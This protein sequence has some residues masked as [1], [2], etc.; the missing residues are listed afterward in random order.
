MKNLEDLI[1]YKK[2]IELVGKTYRLITS[3]QKLRNDFSLID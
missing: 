2:A 1:V 3:N